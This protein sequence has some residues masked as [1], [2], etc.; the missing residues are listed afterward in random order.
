MSSYVYKTSGT[1]S[2]SITVELDGKIIR[3]VS[4]EGGCPG[5]LLGI[6]MLVKGMDMDE[7]I[8]RLNGCRCGNKPTSCPDQLTKAL[9]E[10][11]EAEQKGA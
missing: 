9:A 6:S 11:Y 2:R 8:E 3:S 7:V 10:A 4:F 1:C 5:N